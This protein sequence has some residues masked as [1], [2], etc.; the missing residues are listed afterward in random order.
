MC[1]TKP[2]YPVCQSCG[3]PMAEEKLFGTVAGGDRTDEYCSYCFQNG[4]FTVQLDR[5]AFID[6]QVK[7]AREKMGMD[8]AQAR[9]MAERVIPTLKRWKA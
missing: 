6:M 4:A 9:R 3:M 7:I 5:E 1:L 8:E 2:V